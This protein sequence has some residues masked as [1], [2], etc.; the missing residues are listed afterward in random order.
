MSERELQIANEESMKRERRRIEPN[1]CREGGREYRREEWRQET[2]V[3]FY[4]LKLSLHT[5]LATFDY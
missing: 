3:S 2:L 1:L 5:L 4:S